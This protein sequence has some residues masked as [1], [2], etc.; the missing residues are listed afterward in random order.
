M[1]P[2]QLFVERLLSTVGP[3]TPLPPHRYDEG[4]AVTLLTDGR[5]LVEVDST[6]E[7]STVTRL[8]GEQRDSD[9]PSLATTTTMTFVQNEAE[10]RD[11]PSLWGGTQL[12]TRRFPAD[13][14]QD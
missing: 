2:R 7:L 10:D 9:S 14:E 6:G 4:R 8:A 11:A 5:P 3:E 1:V 12:D 13:V